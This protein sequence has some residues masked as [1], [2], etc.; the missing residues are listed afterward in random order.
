MTTLRPLCAGLLI[1]LVACGGGDAPAP[2][3][4]GDPAPPAQ[5]I[6]DSAMPT[7]TGAGLPPGLAPVVEDPADRSTADRPTGSQNPAGGTRPAP[8][9]TSTQP[10]AGTPSPSP[11]PAV[12]E[13]EAAEILR[14]A[15]TAYE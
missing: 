6:T 9:A 2:A 7:D 5:T 13:D 3:R 4:Q 11:A 12:Q 14:R 15:A 10:P 8:P 1:G